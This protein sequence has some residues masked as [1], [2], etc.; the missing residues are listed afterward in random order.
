MVKHYETYVMTNDEYC[1][2]YLGDLVKKYV[3]EA[4]VQ[5]G[6]VSVITAHTNCGILVT[7]PLPCIMSD[8]DVLLH[9]LVDDGAEYSHA[10]FLPTY[11]RTSANAYGHLRSILIGNNCMFPLVN[12]KLAMGDAQEIVLMEFDGPQSR[13]VFIDILGESCRDQE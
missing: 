1:Y 11:G 4:G 3:A 5:N 13:K 7:E 12:G 2:S 10:H 8:L 6:L 9:K